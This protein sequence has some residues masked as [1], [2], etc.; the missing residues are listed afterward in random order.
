MASLS[1][2]I[3]TYNR[4]GMLAETLDTIRR[5]TYADFELVIVDNA[6]TDNTEE[7]VRSIDDPR[8]RYVKNPENVGLILNQNRAI[9]EARGELV[10]VYHDHDLYD[11]DLV[12]RSVE[13]FEANP[14]VGVV[15]SAIQLVDPDNPDQ[16]YRTDVMPWHEVTPG[17]SV[18]GLLLHEWN[19]PITAPTA[20]V[21]R[22]WYHVAGAFRPEFGGGADREMWLRIFRHCDLG[23]IAEPLARL[24]DRKKIRSFNRTQ[25]D[26]HWNTLKGQVR[27][28]A[29]HLESEFADS[30][31]R[32][33]LERQ[34][35]RYMQFTEFWK[36]ALWAVAQGDN[37]EFLNVAVAAFRDTGMDISARLLDFC[38]RSRFAARSIAAVFQVYKAVNA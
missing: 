6:S 31:G 18:R 7:I 4:A 34:L 3:P 19:S 15:C 1:I 29:V 38:R 33:S 17:R 30:P 26:Y 12:R 22:K 21:R 5:Q 14:N 32:R 2:C 8:L 36:W 10:A 23:Y 24:R 37:T 27:I 20:M 9:E 13:I 35:L 16:V 11:L 25:A 28:Q